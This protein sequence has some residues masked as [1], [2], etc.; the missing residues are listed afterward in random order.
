VFEKI[1][2]NEEKKGNEGNLK[3]EVD[4]KI[5]KWEEKKIKKK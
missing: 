3:K 5:K 2:M 4:I 1:Y